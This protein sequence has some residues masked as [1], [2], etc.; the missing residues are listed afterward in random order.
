[1]CNEVRQLKQDGAEVVAVSYYLFDKVVATELTDIVNSAK[2]MPGAGIRVDEN[3]L[4]EQIKKAGCEDRLN[5]EF[6]KKFALPFGSIFFAFLAYSLAFIF[7]KH[8]GQTVGLFLGI[9]ICVLYW[10]MQIM[11]QLFVQKVGLNP[12]LCI[13]VP[14][15]LIGVVAI[16]FFVKLIKK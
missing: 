14:N 11:G 12:F 7:G 13:W 4:A 8:N 16:F 2:T 6:H 9:V 1:M 15:F 10:A 3:S 5:M